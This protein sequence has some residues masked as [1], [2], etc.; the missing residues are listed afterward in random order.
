MLGDAVLSAAT[1]ATSSAIENVEK[2]A[3]TAAASLISD[4]RAHLRADLNRQLLE[5]R[6]GTVNLSR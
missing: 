4:V 6:V 5:P 1:R 3:W 2:A